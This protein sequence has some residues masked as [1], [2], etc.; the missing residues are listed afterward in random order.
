[1]IRV[2]FVYE[3]LAGFYKRLLSPEPS[4]VFRPIS[5]VQIFYQVDTVARQLR[6]KHRKRRVDMGH[7]VTAVIQD[8]VGHTKLLDHLAQKNFVRLIADTN[9]NLVLTELFALGPQVYPHNSG[10]RAQVPLPHLQRPAF[11]ATDLEENHVSIHELREVAFVSGKIVLPLVNKAL[12]IC[13]KVRPE[14]HE[15]M[16]LALPFPKGKSEKRP[17]SGVVEKRQEEQNFISY[18]LSADQ[19]GFYPAPKPLMA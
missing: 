2:Q 1:M 4:L 11:A 10:I 8:N 14:A 9:V 12:I 17:S 5:G 15:G 6:I 19:V 3:T 7:D 13:Q 18:R 16:V